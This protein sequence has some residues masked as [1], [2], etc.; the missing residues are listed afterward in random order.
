[1]RNRSQKNSTKR[2]EEERR[3][4]PVVCP[5]LE[6]EPWSRELVGKSDGQWMLDE[7]SKRGVDASRIRMVEDEPTAFTVSVSTV[8]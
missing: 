2:W 7:L 1:M 3:S 8:E 6:F 4:P 5:S